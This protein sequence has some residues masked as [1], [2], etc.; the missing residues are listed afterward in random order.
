M[1]NPLS[2]VRG[3]GSAK[4]GTAHW[5]AQRVTAIALV[6]LVVW[7][8]ASLVTL[9][10][11]DRARVVEWLQSPF[12]AIASV[13]LIL[14]VFHHAQLGLQ[15]VIEDYVHKSWTKH[16]LLLLAKFGSAVLAATAIFAVLKIAFA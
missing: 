8:V 7:Y 6:P 2:R 16:T 10:G 14:A 12:A 13:L 1:Q 3:L 11:A 15:V 9:I 5:W 4:E